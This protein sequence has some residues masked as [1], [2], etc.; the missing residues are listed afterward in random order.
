MKLAE[1][2]VKQKKVVKSGFKTISEKI[3]LKHK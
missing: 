1:E 3:D 2:E